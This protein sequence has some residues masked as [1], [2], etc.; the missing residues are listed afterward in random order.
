MTVAFAKEIDFQLSFRRWLS[1]NF[2]KTWYQIQTQGQNF[3]LL[4]E[5]DIISWKLEKNG[6]F[7][8]KSL[9]VMLIKKYGQV[10]F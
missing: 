5:E 9:R 4:S 1:G 2:R 3:V 7:S 8:V 6:K 10:R